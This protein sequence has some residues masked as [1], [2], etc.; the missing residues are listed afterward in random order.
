MIRTPLILASAS[1]RRAQLLKDAG[2]T[3][4]VVPGA[5]EELH[6]EALSATDLCRK[7][8]EIKATDVAS[9]HPESL[10][11]GADTLV[12]LA[13]KLFGKP[14]DI[15]HA[16]AMLAELSGKTHEV[17]TGVCFVQGSRMESFAER[18]EVTFRNLSEKEIDRYLELV[19]VLDKAGAYGIQD[20]GELLVERISGSFSNVMGFPV[21]EFLRRIEKW[22][23]TG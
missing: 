20:R 8:A 19:P 21:E 5:A 9:R 22:K 1:P 2:F 13:G 3:F 17:V 16:R 4:T 10:V 11:I 23:S 15:N 14:R 6:D 7:N 12:A 18:T